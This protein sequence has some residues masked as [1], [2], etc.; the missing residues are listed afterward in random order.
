[1]TE[2]FVDFER[3][4]RLQGSGFTGRVQMKLKDTADPPQFISTDLLAIRSARKLSV[5]LS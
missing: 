3:K 2:S 5:D 1:M 4:N